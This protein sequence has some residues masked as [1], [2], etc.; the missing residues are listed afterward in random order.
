MDIGSGMAPGT[1]DPRQDD[2]TWFELMRGYVARL[3][4]HGCREFKTGLDQLRFTQ[5][6][7]ERIE[8]IDAKVRR[9]CG[10]GVR[11]VDGLLPSDEFYPMLQRRIFPIAH[12]LRQPEELEFSVLPDLFHDSLGHLPLL[13][14]PVYSGFLD[15]Y[16]GVA[17]KFLDNPQALRL[18]GRLY[19]YAIET[20]LVMEH[21]RLKILGAAIATSAA[22]CDAVYSGRIRV[23]PFDFARVFASDYDTFKL[24]KQYFVLD[25]FAMLADLGA[26]IEDA[27]TECLSDASIAAS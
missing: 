3:S 8:D 27:L 23:A 7:A 22:E 16:S 12:E 9:A 14:S 20:G 17:L 5:Q 21:G 25:S 18:L 24:Q 26:R 10:W 19:W 15:A 13:T 1:R 6:V 11:A 2:R 4:L